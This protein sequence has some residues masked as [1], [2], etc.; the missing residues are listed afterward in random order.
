MD[1]HSDRFED[2]SLLIYKDEELV[3]L[4]P[5]N[6]KGNKVYSHQGLTYGGVVLSDVIKFDVVLNMFLEILKY[7][8]NHDI[9]T[10][11]LKQI[12]FIYNKLPSD[13]V[14][15][16]MFIL[17]AD[18]LKMETLSVLYLDE[19]LKISKDRAN[20]FKR[21]QKHNLE[22]REEDK[23]DLFWN[24]ILIKNLKDKH[25]VKPVHSLEEITLLKKQF[26]NNIRQFNVYHNEEIVAGTTI[27][28]SKYVAHS[29]YISG[30]A[31][32]N[33][34]GS[35]DFLHKSLIDDVFKS[36]ERIMFKPKNYSKT[37][38]Y[39]SKLKLK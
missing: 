15:Y 17:K 11:E 30:N 20:G 10:L 7:F 27:F 16:L 12:P 4:L 22:I 31:N 25:S 33:I 3:G 32:K 36:I 1:Y 26:P 24:T 34:F 13:E 8:H 9:K 28:E 6:R 14:K 2:F 21:G 23:L 5:A 37:E 39:T 35:L 18:V 29:Q 38:I 19:K